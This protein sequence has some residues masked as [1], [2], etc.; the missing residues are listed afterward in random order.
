MRKVSLELEVLV[1]NRVGTG[2]RITGSFGEAGFKERVDFGK[3]IGEY[4]LKKEGKPT[5]YIPT[6]KGTIIYA[7]DGTVHVVPSSPEA[8][9]K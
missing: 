8:I 4:A 6:S 5:Q 9:I 7:K 2:Q 1:K 3:I